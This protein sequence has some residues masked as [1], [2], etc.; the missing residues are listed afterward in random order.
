MD[1]T[2]EAMDTLEK[3]FE[4]AESGR[5]FTE[6][7]PERLRRWRE[8]ASAALTRLLV[9]DRPALEGGRGIAWPYEVLTRL[10]PEFRK[11]EAG[12]SPHAKQARLFLALLPFPGQWRY[13]DRAAR[14]NA[15]DPEVSAFIRRERDNIQR[16]LA[17]KRQKTFKLRHFCQILKAP[18]LPGEKGI[19]RIFSIPYLFTVPGLLPLL[20]KHYFLYIEPAAGVVYRHTWMR[21]F[22]RLSDPVLFGLSGKE[23][24]AFHDS[25]EKILTTHLAHGDYLDPAPEPLPRG[26]IRHDIVFNATFDEMERKRHHFMLELLGHPEL[27]GRTALFLGRGDEEKVAGFRRDV[28]RAGL[29]DR[30]TVLANIKRGEVPVHLSRCRIGVHLALHENGCRCVYEFFRENLP[31][32]VSSSMA[33]INFAT[34][35]GQT[36]RAASDPD[37]PRAIR[38]TLE[39][40]ER[41]SPRRWFLSNSG[42]IHASAELGELLKGIFHRLGYGWS[43]DIAPLTS[44]GA[45]RYLHA[46][47]YARFKPAYRELYAL[48]TGLPSLPI[49]LAEE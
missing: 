21:H 43:E 35:N 22:A 46:E 25:Q 47:D 23:D 12:G 26:E 30:V 18:K 32:V 17:K 48:M 13:L 11:L 5:L 28:E 27:Y 3:F 36:G 24:A 19:L 14:E 33:G 10:A 41:H 2:P 20:D 6:G 34:I 1:G 31:V 15:D 45:N 7:T 40:P 44:S 9:W 39:A 16:K 38:E 8:E 37:L 42:S 4:T 29:S 49:R